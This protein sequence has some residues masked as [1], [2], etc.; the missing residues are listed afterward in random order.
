MLM[1]RSIV[2]DNLDKTI[3][4]IDPYQR[5]AL[6]HAPFKGT[7]LFGGELARVYRASKERAS[8]VNV[9]PAVPSVINHPALHR[10]W[11]I[12]QERWLFLQ[13]GRDRDRS[14]S[15][16]S[17]TVTRLSKSG[18]GQSTMTVTVPQEPN[19]RHI[20]AHENAPPSKRH[21]SRKRKSHKKE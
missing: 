17:S 13:S 5:V 12:L 21:K 11:E 10:P 14:K 7:T 18:D 2:L 9:Y 4:T 15:T 8:S 3:L 16:P 6:L 1:R 20:Q 19:K